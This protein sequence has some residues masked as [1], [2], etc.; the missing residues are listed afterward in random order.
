MNLAFDIMNIAF[1]TMFISISYLFMKFYPKEINSVVGY[2]TK[3]SMRS[4]EAWELSNSHAGKLL[5]R[6]SL[7]VAVLQ[8]MLYVFFGGFVSL[9]GML[10]A[11][12]V[13]LIIAI[14]QTE[15]LLKNEGY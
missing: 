7:L 12:I 14:V 4:Q 2:R 10:G 13:M 6:Y 8:L 1:I 5:L 11:W 9:L 15:R 3:R